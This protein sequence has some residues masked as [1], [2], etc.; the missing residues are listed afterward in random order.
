M[1]LSAEDHLGIVCP[2]ANEGPDAVRFTEQVLQYCPPKFTVTF[3][4]VLDNITKDNTVELL[5]DYAKT[6]KR[7]RVVW[8]PENRC[9]VDAYVRGYREALAAGC[10]WILEIDAGFS[11]QPDEVPGF[12]AKI[13]EAYD[14]VFGSRFMPGG[15]MVDKSLKRY[16]VSRGG[17]W[18]ANLMLGTRQTDMTSGFELFSRRALRMILARGIHSRAHFFQTEIKFYCRNL[19]YIEIPIHYRSPSPRL[20]SS[21]INDAF[22]Q[23]WRLTKERRV[24]QGRKENLIEFEDNACRNFDLTS[25]LD[26]R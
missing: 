9:V 7:L 20:G 14:C 24:S 21:A 22:R 13:N 6:E 12:L 1:P 3:F 16:L 8:A 2:M 4:A 25:K 10:T 18:L 26:S 11:H 5:H 17:T 15:A 23:L 19:N